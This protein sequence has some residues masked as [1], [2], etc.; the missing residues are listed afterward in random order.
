VPSHPSYL[1]AKFCTVLNSFCIKCLYVLLLF[2]V[3]AW[4]KVPTMF[5]LLFGFWDSQTIDYVELNKHGSSV[6]SECMSP[7]IVMVMGSVADT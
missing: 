2:N 7:T 5:S 3:D 6:F 1:V 4:D